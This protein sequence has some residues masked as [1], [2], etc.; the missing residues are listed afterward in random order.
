MLWRLPISPPM[1]G[2]GQSRAAGNGQE[3]REKR[4]EKRFALH[5]FQYGL[6][7]AGGGDRPRR[8]RSVYVYPLPRMRHTLGPIDLN[9]L[10]RLRS[11][12]ASC[13]CDWP[14]YQLSRVR[15]RARGMYGGTVVLGRTLPGNVRLKTFWTLYRGFWLNRISVRH[16]LVG[17][18]GFTL[19]NLHA[20][21]CV[22]LSLAPMEHTHAIVATSAN[23]TL[24]ILQARS[25]SQ[26]L[27]GFVIFL[28]RT[29]FGRASRA[30]S[31]HPF[32]DHAWCG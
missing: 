17:L 31:G 28:E 3:C 16:G 5:R 8:R 22:C 30:S 10:E 20:R 15:R 2:S 19:A 11:R 7:G 12:P 29:A 14:Y 13:W 21:E 4:R 25:R 1:P 24:R 27:S 26:V 9:R 6:E 18:V 32:L 23:R